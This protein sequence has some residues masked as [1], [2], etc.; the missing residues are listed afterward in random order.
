MK[1]TNAQIE[2][3]VRYIIEELKTQKLITF[4]EKES[5]VFQRALEIVKQ[6][7]EDE[8]QLDAEVNAMMDDLEKQHPGGFQRYK[9]F[10][11]LKKKLAQ[12]KGFVL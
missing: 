4:K 1:V 7:Q 2:R 5:A 12:E 11:M 3:L 10:P 6:N 8:K 9:M